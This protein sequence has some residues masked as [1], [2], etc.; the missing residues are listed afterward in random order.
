MLIYMLM[1]QLH[2][3]HSNFEQLEVILQSALT[4]LFIWLVANKLKLSAPKSTCMVIG[5]HQRTHGK[6]IHLFFND[7][8]LRQASTVVYT[9]IDQHLTW[10]CHIEY[11]LRRVCGKLYSINH[12]RP[13]IDN[14]MKILY[15]T[16]ISP[17]I[18]YCDFVWA[19]SNSS[20]LKRLE[21]VHL[22]FVPS[23]STN[24]PVFK[25]SW[26]KCTS[27]ICTCY[28]LKLW[29]EEFILPCTWNSYLE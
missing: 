13:L 1:T 3:C 20:H 25:L 2:Y 18:D 22:R 26:P 23:I 24:C 4:Q 28:T 29:K 27:L 12:L 8:A 11:V 14:V 21:R 15:Q 9:Y 5:S 16:H 6:V 10:K 19:P 7:T 17:I